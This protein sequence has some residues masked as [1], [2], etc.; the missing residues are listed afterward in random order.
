MIDKLHKRYLMIRILVLTLLLAPPMQ[1]LAHE[2]EDHYDRVHLSASAQAQVANDTVITMLYAQE[3]GRDSVQLANLVNKR[4][5]NAIEHVKQYDAIKVQTSGYS[6]TPVYHNNKITG[7]RIRQSIRLESQDMALVS[8]VLG[9]LQQTLALQGMNFTVSPELKNSTDD[10]LIEQ[11][12]QV[13]ERRAQKV[14]QQLG[15]KNYKIVD[16]DIST[17]ADHYPRRNY[18]VA[19]MATKVAAPAIEGGEQTLRVTVSGKIEME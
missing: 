18:D 6:T 3:E 5:E 15:R 7:W 16:I 8:D 11:A 10:Q 14:T 4:V 1:S 2:T 12:L 9:Q 19:A 17:A 13:F